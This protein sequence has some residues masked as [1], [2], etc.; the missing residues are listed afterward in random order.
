MLSC[1]FS[2]FVLRLALKSIQCLLY[3]LECKGGRWVDGKAQNEEKCMIHLKDDSFVHPFNSVPSAKN[4][5]VILL[6]LYVKKKKCGIYSSTVGSINWIAIWPINSA[7]GWIRQ[8]IENRL[9]KRSALFTK[10]SSLPKTH[11]WKDGE[12][13]C[14]T[15][16]RDIIQLQGKAMP[17][18]A[19]QL[20]RMWGGH[21]ASWRVRSQKKLCIRW[22]HLDEIL[23]LVKFWLYSQK[24][25]WWLKEGRGWELSFSSARLSR[26]MKIAQ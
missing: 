8:I 26:I 3:K 17:T 22:F 23:R 19:T 24:A 18:V 1:S 20:H 13:K 7:S 14:D 2:L 21:Y 6:Y 10:G 9:W 16:T 4:L 15:Y 11:G 25:E 5:Q 12:I